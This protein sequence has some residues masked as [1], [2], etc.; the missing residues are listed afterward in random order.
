MDFSTA[1]GKYKAYMSQVAFRVDN[2]DN[3]NAKQDIE[4]ELSVVLWNCVERYKDKTDKELDGILKSAFHNRV[5]NIL[6]SQRIERQGLVSIDMKFTDKNNKPN[7]FSESISKHIMT[8]RDYANGIN[9]IL[10]SLSPESAMKTMDV[11]NPESRGVFIKGTR[12]AYG[13]IQAYLKKD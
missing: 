7:K 4:Q 2:W 9:E 8:D 12:K 6:K 10:S 11:L 5:V 13:E 3:L 1:Y